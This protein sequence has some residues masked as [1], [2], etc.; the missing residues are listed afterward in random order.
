MRTMPRLSSLALMHA[1]EPLDIGNARLPNFAGRHTQ[2]PWGML[3]H[4]MLVVIDGLPG[5]RPDEVG[6]WVADSFGALFV[7]TEHL[8]AALVNTSLR[9]GIDVNDVV[10]VRN[11]S[12]T[13]TVDV[14]FATGEGAP[15]AEFIINGESSTP[16]ELEA[17]HSF[18]HEINVFANFR[19]LFQKALSECDFHD[20][21][22]MVGRNNGPSLLWDTPYKFFLDKTDGSVEPEILSACGYPHCGNPKRYYQ[23]P[24]FFCHRTNALMVDS[25]RTSASDLVVIVLVE[26]VARASEMGFLD[27]PF[28]AHFENACKLAQTVRKQIKP[29]KT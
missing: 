13:A 29:L 24:T 5:T 18:A 21:I 27:G 10:N 23:G 3:P 22:I 17:V 1:P 9:E 2:I 7:N 4:E 20:R 6:M 26:S 28:E 14:R 8:Q 15:E 25:T 16:E 19:P 12:A 11:W